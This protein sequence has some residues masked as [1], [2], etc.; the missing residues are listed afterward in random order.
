ME[1][2]HSIFIL[3]PATGETKGVTAAEL[4]EPVMPI[5][6]PTAPKT[7]AAQVETENRPHKK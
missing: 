2:S 7:D 4:A 1:T 6:E 5:P 3:D